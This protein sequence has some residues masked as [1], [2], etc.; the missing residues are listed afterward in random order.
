MLQYLGTNLTNGEPVTS[1]L[2]VD[3]YDTA[4]F[5]RGTALSAL[6]FC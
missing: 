1:D 5:V 2:C 4:L 6:N 3:G